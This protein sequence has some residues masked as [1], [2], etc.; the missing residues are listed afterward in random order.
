MA[1]GEDQ[2]QPVVNQPA[3]LI[4]HPP[5]LLHARTRSHVRSHPTGRRRVGRQQL[6][7]SGGRPG[8]A[9]PVDRPAP[10]RRQQPGPWTGGHTVA[11][12]RHHG[13]DERVLDR[14]LSDLEIADIADHRGKHGRPVVAERPVQRLRRG[15]LSS[16]GKSSAVT[17]GRT[18]TEPYSAIGSRAAASSAT[19]R[20]GQSNR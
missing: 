17:T 18:S 5:D 9:D 11:G 16:V 8:T 14:V 4:G 3:V 7:A 10:S 19:S 2:P 20:F 6:R 12:P 1:A 15:H 13:R